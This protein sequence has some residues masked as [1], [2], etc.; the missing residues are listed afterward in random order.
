M[1]HVRRNL[2]WLSA[3]L[4]L[5]LS[6][7]GTVPAGMAPGDAPQPSAQYTEEHPSSSMPLLQWEENPDAVSY[8]LEMFRK[9]PYDLPQNRLDDKSSYHNDQIYTNS[10]MIDLNQ[11]VP[12]YSD[13]NPLYWRVRAMDFYGRPITYFSPLQKM[14]SNETPPERN[15][16]LPRI[17]YN[18]GYGT[19]I[20]YPVYSFVPNPGATQFEVELT[21]APPENTGGTEPSAHRVFS[22][23]T[24]EVDHYDQSPRIGTY[25]WRIRGLD[26][27][28]NPVGVWSEAQKFRTEPDDQWEIGII[29]DSISHGGGHLSY[30]PADWEYSYASYLDFPTI[31][32]SRSGDT[33]ETMVERFDSDVLPFHLKYLLIMDGTNS[34][35]ADVSPQDVIRDLQEMQEKCRENGIT[36]ILLTL[37]PI[38][39]DNIRNAFQ[40]DTFGNW[41]ANF[42]EV[43]DFILTQPH[44]DTASAFSGMKSMPTDLALDGLHGDW[45]AKEMIADV[46]NEHIEE[47]VPD[48][49]Q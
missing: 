35:R 38:N 20:L 19:T 15:A 4:V 14:Y 10:V 22:E 18:T 17:S 23:I 25:Y 11:A 7:T 46:I 3:A 1:M 5:S 21:D 24:T 36:P 32:L 27:N 41:Q 12:G 37:P 9:I 45:R 49:P 39:P 2:I 16:P 47:F 28:G 13:L 42:R 6:C 40:Q 44:I 8:E 34:L 30:A 31:N 33:S 48:L 29:G 26:A 43:N